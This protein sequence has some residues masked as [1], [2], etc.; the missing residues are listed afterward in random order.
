[1]STRKM[2]EILEIQRNLYNLL[3]HIFLQGPAQMLLEQLTSNR[4]LISED[5]QQTKLGTGLM[6]L[7]TYIANHPGDSAQLEQDLKIEFTRLLIGPGKTPVYPYES[8]YVSEKEKPSLMAE[9]T[10]KVREKYLKAQVVM[11]NLYSVPDDHLGAEMEF[12]YYL[13]EKALNALESDTQELYDILEEQRAFLEEHVMKWVPEFAD[14]LYCATNND[15]FRGIAIVLGEL[16]TEH[17][18]YLQES[19]T[20]KKP[21]DENTEVTI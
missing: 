3:R 7:Y 9:T 20:W 4:I 1:M 21:I 14:K 13:C 19:V 6:R 8:V 10:L 15:F 16:I 2:Q 12:L 17:S 5:V 11:K 18:L